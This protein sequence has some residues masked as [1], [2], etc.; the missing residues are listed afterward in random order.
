MME[1]SD[2]SLKVRFILIE[3]TYVRAAY[4]TKSYFI[5][6]QIQ[7]INV[8][9]YFFIIFIHKKLAPFITNTNIKFV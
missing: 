1:L 7:S 9:I 2:L 5:V 4:E 6:N 8:N 3:N